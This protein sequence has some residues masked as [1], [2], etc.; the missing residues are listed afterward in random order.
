MMKDKKFMKYDGKDGDAPIKP[1]YELIYA[2]ALA[3]EVEVLTFGAQK[4]EP[5]NWARCTSVMRYFGALMRHMF[6]WV[7]G[8]D[9]D[10][11]TGLS[12][13]AHARCCLMFMKG[14]MDLNPIADDRPFKKMQRKK[15]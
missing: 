1:Q 4:Y 14:L 15:Q 8:E 6:A 11:E 2:P 3:E 12:H 5:N 7:S 9:I 13:F 10:P